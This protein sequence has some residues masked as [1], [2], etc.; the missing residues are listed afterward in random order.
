VDDAQQRAGAKAGTKLKPW[1]ELSPAPAIHADLATATTLPAPDKNCSAGAI[2]I[3]LGE[4]KRLADPKADA[5]QDHDQ[6]PEPRTVWPSPAARM[7]ATISSTVG[8]SAG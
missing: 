3:G 1:L 8:G 6:R 7:T 2:E 5:P 4:V